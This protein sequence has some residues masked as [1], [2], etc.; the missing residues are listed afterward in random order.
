MK[1]VAVELIHEEM[2]AYLAAKASDDRLK[3][4]GALERAHILSQPYL[5]LHMANHW[6]MLKFACETRDTKEALGQI[7]RLALAPL[8]ALTGRIP[9]GNTGRSNVSAF[10]SMPIPD[11]LQMLLRRKEP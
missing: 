4:W 5:K 9:L 1:S 2:A 11:D 8:G 6:A 3:A 7:V 10:K